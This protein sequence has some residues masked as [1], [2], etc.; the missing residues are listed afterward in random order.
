MN[1]THLNSNSTWLN[2]TE[3]NRTEL[4][5]I[6]LINL[7]WISLNPAWMNLTRC[8]PNVTWLTSIECCLS[9]VRPRSRGS[10][11]HLWM[12]WRFSSQ[13]KTTDIEYRHDERT[14]ISETPFFS[15]EHRNRRVR[16]RLEGALDDT[17]IR[18]E[19][20]WTR[21]FKFKTEFDVIRLHWKSDRSMSKRL[22]R[23]TM[24]CAEVRRDGR[25]LLFKA[26]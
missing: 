13:K 2:W 25:G 4:S 17:M 21:T 7:N 22:T 26:N 18:E 5:Q 23:P 12:S 11:R 20:G 6:A 19:T 9:E 24:K 15:K 10:A 1:Q 3:V 8:Q 14:V 16:S